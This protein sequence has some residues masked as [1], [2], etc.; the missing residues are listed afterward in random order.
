MS[1]SG[2]IIAAPASN[3]GK[4]FLTLGI[5]R[6]LKKSGLDIG[7]L[8][9]GPD[10][11][12]P[13]FHQA[14]TQKPC[15]N[16]DSW[17]MRDASLAF[18]F[19]TLSKACRGLVCEGVM[20]LFDGASLKKPDPRHDGS[21]ASLA[22]KTGWPVV[23]VIDA[24]AQAASVAALIKG[25][26]EFDPEVHV[27]GVIFNKVGSQSHI[28]LIEM[29]CRIHLPELR[30]FGF[31]PRQ[32]ALSL[33]ARHLGLVT[34][35]EHRALESFLEHSADFL[36]EHVDIEGLADLALSSPYSGFS[37]AKEAFFDPIGQ[38]IAVAQD[39]AFC[40]CYPHLLDHWRKQG[41]EIS[42]FSPLEDEVPHPDCDAIYLPGGYPELHA[43]KISKAHRFQ[44]ALRIKSETAKA[45]FGE[46][47]GYMVLGKLII[48]DKGRPH[49]MCGL[50][51]L[52]TSYEKRK[53][54]LGYR[55]LSLRYD[56]PFAPKGT[57]LRAHEFHYSSVIEEHG[58]S[59]FEG[60]NAKGENL[61]YMGLTKGCV[62]GSFMHLID[63]A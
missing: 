14:A 51:N 20:G 3:S 19:E 5:L 58:Q 55:E 28:E 17:A 54:H 40:F 6:A 12:D 24:T 18:Q 34:A 16:L 39:P 10:Y 8:K 26:S 49:P 60:Q 25:F 63:R 32:N 33:P 4:T 30:I 27:A 43:E 11:I 53:L 21:A 45:I 44:T 52:T 42:F 13:G 46:C 41:A 1:L 35:S 57:K 47:G 48:D 22:R 62:S 38:R 15:P 23:L 59:L 36:A 50:L 2:L 9:I 29:A 61:D 31:V 37:D 56:L 7:S